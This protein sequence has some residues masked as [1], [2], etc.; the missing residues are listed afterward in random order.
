VKNLDPDPEEKIADLNHGFG[1]EIRFF[2]DP[3]IR[4]PDPG[5]KKFGSKIRDPGI[6]PRILFLRTYPF[7]GL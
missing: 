2:F 3:W 1:F 5:W 7:F 6:T 4:D